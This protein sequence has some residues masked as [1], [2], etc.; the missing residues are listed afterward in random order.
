M[1]QVLSQTVESVP[2]SVGDS[3]F[4]YVSIPKTE[5]DTLNLDY[6]EKLKILSRY[7]TLRNGVKYNTPFLCPRG[8]HVCG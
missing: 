2:G 4:C 6:I 8:H 3:G 7:L 1:G 5:C